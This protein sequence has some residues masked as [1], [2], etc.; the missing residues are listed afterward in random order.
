MFRRMVSVIAAGAAALLLASTGAE[1]A[2]VNS[3]L[4]AGPR[5]CNDTYPTPQIRLVLGPAAVICYDG[6]H[7]STRVDDIYAT[8][9]ASGGYWGLVTCT[10]L[11][12]YFFRPNEFVR[13]D[14]EVIW[15][16]IT[17]PNWGVPE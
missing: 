12:Q 11:K 2:S 3:G 16:R 10:D 5:P 6:H 14:C 4:L 8:G 7:G 17:A 15:I 1:A 13:L 9:L